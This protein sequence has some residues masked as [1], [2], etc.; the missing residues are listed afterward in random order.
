MATKKGQD[1]YQSRAL[2]HEGKEECCQLQFRSVQVL[3]APAEGDQQG[4]V[5][6]VQFCIVSLRRLIRAGSV[7]DGKRGWRCPEA[8][9][10][11][12]FRLELDDG[13]CDLYYKGIWSKMNMGLADP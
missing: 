6:S 12:G 11:F 2:P 7:P 5:N 3:P 8:A 13:G 4:G 9:S 10:F 1:P